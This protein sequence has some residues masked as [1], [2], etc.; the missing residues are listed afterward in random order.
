[1]TRQLPNLIN[2]TIVESSLF[3]LFAQALF[4]ALVSFGGIAGV[5][6]AFRPR[7]FFGLTGPLVCPPGSEMVMN[8]WSDGAPTSSAETAGC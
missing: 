1:M 3:S 6:I 5:L 4:I 7:F 8:Q 2:R